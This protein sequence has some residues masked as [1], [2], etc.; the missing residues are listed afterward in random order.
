MRPDHVEIQLSYLAY[1]AYSLLVA[2]QPVEFAYAANPGIFLL[3]SR[4]ITAIFGIGMI[5]VA[6]LIGKRVASRVGFLAAALFAVFPPF[7]T[8]SHYATPDVPLTF[9]LMVL[10][11][12]LM[13]YI[14]QPGYIALLVASA[15]TAFSI[16]VKYPG[17]LATLMIAVVVIVAGVRDRRFMR[18]LT[19][20]AIAIVAVNGF[21]FLISPVLFTNLRGVLAAIQQ[22]SR[23]THPGA[24]GLSWGGNLLFY[25][26]EFAAIAGI[27]L[28]VASVA[29]IVFSWRRRLVQIIPIGLGGLFWIALSALPLHWERWGLPMYTAPLLLAAIGIHFGAIALGE[30]RWTGRWRVPLLAV[31]GVLIL[32]N[33]LTGSLGVIARLLAPDSR[34]ELQPALEELSIT[35]NNSIWEGYSPFQPGKG[36]YI[37][38]DFTT[39]DGTGVP[40]DPDKQYVV[41]SGCSYQRFLDE[42]KY[43]SEQNFYAAI[44]NTFDEI[45]VQK[46]VPPT[47]LSAFEPVSIVRGIAVLREFATGGMGGCD[48]SVY[49]IVPTNVGLD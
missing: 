39:A 29:G 7:V 31:V 26:G 36:K 44:R 14:E 13:S 16:A 43:G 2:H 4:A 18:I 11:L 48:V 3:I 8:H 30:Q 23:T 21:L 34:L 1:E 19:Q 33:L 41:L 12:A 20:G 6:W 47:E 40:V 9:F 5:V 45:L 49:R 17:A 35:E 37:F 10:V 15:A 27:L 38:G 32:A 25:A 24:D 22:E 42:E 28:A 46:I